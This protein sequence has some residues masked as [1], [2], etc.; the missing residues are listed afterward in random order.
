MNSVNIYN[1]TFTGNQISTRI[2]GKPGCEGTKAPRFIREVCTDGTTPLRNIRVGHASGRRPSDKEED[3]EN[4]CIP[5][6]SVLCSPGGRNTKRILKISLPSWTVKKPRNGGLF[7]GVT[8][9]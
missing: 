9:S 3:F 2:K 5:S 8:A 4:G 6:R 7:R 1:P